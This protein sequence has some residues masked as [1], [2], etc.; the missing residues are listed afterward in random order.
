MSN[1]KNLTKYK[2]A[3]FMELATISFP[4]MISALSGNVMMFIDR[5]ILARYSADAMTAVAASGMACAIFMFGVVSTVSIAEV[6]V[7]QYN[8]AGK[9]EKVAEPVWQMIFFSLALVIV[10]WPLALF[11]AELFIP[12]G[13]EELGIPYFKILMFFAVLN[14]IWASLGAFFAGIGNPKIITFAAITGNIVNFFLDILLVFGY[15]DYIPA[16]GT[17]GAAIA[18]VVSLF[19]QAFILA[20]VFLNKE[21]AKKYATRTAKF[22]KSTMLDCL[23]VGYPNSVGHMLE[24]LAWLVMFMLAGIA[25]P[26]HVIALALGQTILILFCFM[27]DGLQKGVIAVSSNLI[28]AGLQDKIKVML[29][30]AFKL[31][32]VI[33]LLTAIPILFYPG[34]LIAAFNIDP[35]NAGSHLSLFHQVELTLAC[36][37]LYIIFD[38]LVWIFAGVLTSG[39][40]TKFVMVANAVSVWLFGILPVYLL[41]NYTTTEPYYI[42]A[43]TVVYA[44]FNMLW[45]MLR[46]RQGKWRKLNLSEQTSS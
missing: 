18:T 16:M 4:L 3:S 29:F 39:G 22:V 36:C 24:M 46:F 40:D 30:S 27:S 14:P 17:S 28:G 11:G 1:Y 2:S 8:G 33:V 37:W 45:F 25:S 6:F 5:L 32:G 15:G 23:K 42:W 10:F 12:A 34:L 21:N 20:V 41:V 43:I 19:I 35:S 13:L 7:G 26:N 38:G 44:I 9:N 31:H